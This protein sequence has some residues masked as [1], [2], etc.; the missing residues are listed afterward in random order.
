M[1]ALLLIFCIALLFS[2][3]SAQSIGLLIKS[4][5][6]LESVPDE[7]AAFSKFKEVLKIQPANIYA[8]NKCSELCSRI[9]QRQTDKKLRDD[10]YKAAERYAGISLRL[11]SNNAEANCVMAVALGKSSLSKS[12]KEKIINAKEIKKYVDRS[13]QNNPQNFVAWHVLGRWNYE[14]GNLNIIER[15]AARIFYGNI[16]EGSMD[17]AIAAFE[18]S[19][20]ISEGFILNYLELAKAYKK[21]GQN[22]KAIAC[23]NK[24]LVLPNKTEDD[25]SIKEQGKKLLKEWQY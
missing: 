15:T 10:Y 3:A 5:D 8:L 21:N 19:S 12:G 24:M 2:N 13:L 20:S 16:P 18:K 22:K 4:A 1:R 17:N 11:D 25:A 23:I 6:K 7:E 9:G 14:L